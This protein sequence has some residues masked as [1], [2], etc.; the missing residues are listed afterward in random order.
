MA[1]ILKLT[2]RI[3]HGAFADVFSPDPGDRVFKLFRRLTDPVLKGVA[4]H[5]FRAEV[6]AYEAV[7]HDPSLVSHVPRFFGST[8][9]SAV[10]GEDGSDSSAEYWL[11]L[12]YILGRLPADP[13]ERKVGSFFSPKEWHLMAPFEERFEAVGVMHLGD[14]SVLH[15]RSERPM[16]IDFGLTDAAADHAVIPRGAA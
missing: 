2:D 15:W 4:P 13:E 6:G 8:Q 7:A 9:V 14:A 16:F 11:D 10:I 12:C 1:T 5:V 3:A